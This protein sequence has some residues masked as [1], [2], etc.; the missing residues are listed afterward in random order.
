M[1]IKYTFTIDFFHVCNFEQT[2]TK[3]RPQNVACLISK[4]QPIRKMTMMSG[5]LGM[6][7]KQAATNAGVR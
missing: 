2:L 1:Q 7:N 5:G 3:P 6:F 4:A